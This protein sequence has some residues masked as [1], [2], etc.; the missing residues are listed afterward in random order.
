MRH[1]ATLQDIVRLIDFVS[2]SFPEGLAILV[3]TAEPPSTLEICDA[4]RRGTGSPLSTASKYGTV[5][6]GGERLPQA[7]AMLENEYEAT[8]AALGGW[9]FIAK[10]IRQFREQYPETWALFE[11]YCIH[12]RKGGSIHLG[13]G[14][15]VAMCSSR[16][17]GATART[18]SR[19]RK[20]I[21]QTI[22]LHVL[23]RPDAPIVSHSDAIQASKCAADG[24]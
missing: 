1:F 24:R 8:V 12:V 15:G 2:K 17:D 3:G 6:Q 13:T 9:N 21:V 23:T 19:R 22:A 10:A 14:G 18:L 4:L 16:Y 7:Q 11:M 20:K 5:I